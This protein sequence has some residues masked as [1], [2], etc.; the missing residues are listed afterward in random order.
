VTGCDGDHPESGARQHGHHAEADEHGHGVTASSDSRYITIAL[1]L[2]VGFLVFEVVMAFAGH[3][4]AL[5][6]DAGHMLTD[7][8]ALGAS[9]LAIRLARR[10]ASGARTFGFKR[11]EVLSAQ[12]NGI[13]LLVI[14]ALVAFEA[15]SRLIRPLPV[16]G[17][18]VLTV[19]AMGVAVNVAATWVMARA[20]RGSVNVRGAFAPHTSS[21]TCTPSSARWRR[22]S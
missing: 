10:P 21:P 22:E 9:L 7:A 2:L 19:A 12:A 17:G 11:A 1:G 20:N 16:T 18:I 14:S 4:L 6:A 3:S 15:V 8:G 13:T 5:L